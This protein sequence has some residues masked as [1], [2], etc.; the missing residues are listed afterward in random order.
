MTEPVN[1]VVRVRWANGFVDVSD[2]VA[3]SRRKTIPHDATSIDTVE[4]AIEIGQTVL[5]AAAE[6]STIDIDVV[7]TDV[8]PILGDGVSTLDHAGDPVIGPL[9]KRRVT[10]RPGGTAALQP[11]IGSPSEDVIER[12]QI[13]LKRLSGSTSQGGAGA[14]IGPQADMMLSGKLSA[15]AFDTWSWDPLDETDGHK[16]VISEDL[17]L[18]K[19]N[20]TFAYGDPEAEDEESRG[21]F[22][23]LPHDVRFAWFIDDTLGDGYWHVP[24]GTSK[25][26]AL[27]LI[28]LTLGQTFQV[29]V[30]DVYDNTLADMDG[31]LATVQFR[32]APGRLA[33]P[34]AGIPIHATTVGV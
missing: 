11:T 6:R 19:V 8:W 22:T 16:T 30:W 25:W 5:A 3:S 29:V 7:D 24:A 15:P 4:R 27:G 9:R 13:R 23:S 1:Y 12:Q 18:T 26:S 2:G 31:V 10:I 34:G 32:T 21:E 28:E 17:T 33:R 20:I 14:M